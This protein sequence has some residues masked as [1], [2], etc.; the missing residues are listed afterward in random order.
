MSGNTKGFTLLELMI[1]I[2][3]IAIMAAIAIPNMIRFRIQTN[4]TAAIGNL[5]TITRA[6]ATFTGAERGYASSFNA[7]RDAPLQAG[8]IPYL[9]I[10]FNG[11]AVRGYDY[12][13]E[14]AGA[15]VATSSGVDGFTNFH[16]RANPANPGSFGSG[17]YFYFTDAS[18]VI[19]WDRDGPAD[20]DSNII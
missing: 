17:I 14:E 18:G 19:R 12:E 16:C 4:Q 10:D 20:E 3:I 6:Q 1:V 11:G 2:Q 15:A 9:D 8:Q 7:L 5:A 13:L